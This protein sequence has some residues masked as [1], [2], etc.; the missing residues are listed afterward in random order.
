M[1][2]VLTSFQKES[3]GEVFPS[4]IVNPKKMDENVCISLVKVKNK[5]DI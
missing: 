1:W 3:P 2:L 4:E 5:D